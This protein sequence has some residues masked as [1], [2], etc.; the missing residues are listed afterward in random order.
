M[1]FSDR[2]QTMRRM[3][4]MT[5]EQLAEKMNYSARSIQ[6]WESS[7]Q[8]PPVKTIVRLADFLSTSL[9]YLL[10]RTDYPVFVWRNEFGE[11]AEGEP[12]LITPNDS[13]ASEHG[14]KRDNKDT[15]T[16]VLSGER[17]EA[18]DEMIDAHIAASKKKDAG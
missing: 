10:C 12:F 4:G 17:K 16:L 9:D 7:A 8:I 2:L 18:L 11:T 5:Q 1:A 13:S 15:I 6:A 3:R 14:E